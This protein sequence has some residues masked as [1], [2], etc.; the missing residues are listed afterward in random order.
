MNPDRP[1]VVG[2]PLPVFNCLPAV[3]KGPRPRLTNAERRLRRRGRRRAHGTLASFRHVGSCCG[4]THETRDDIRLLSTRVVTIERTA[5][6][7][8]TV[9]GERLQDFTEGCPP[10]AHQHVNELRIHAAILDVRLV[11]VKSGCEVRLGSVRQGLRVSS[12][13]GRGRAGESQITICAESRHA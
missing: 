11:V 6:L 1:A 3:E 9:Q 12:A 7:F 8:Q 4:S 13:S 2:P 10:R 5:Q